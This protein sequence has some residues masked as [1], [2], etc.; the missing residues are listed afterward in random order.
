[1]EVRALALGY[2]SENETMFLSG[3]MGARAATR[4]LPPEG[5]PS[6]GVSEASGAGTEAEEPERVTAVVGMDSSEVAEMAMRLLT[7]G[8]PVGVP[9]ADAEEAE[10]DTAAV[11]QTLMRWWWVGRAKA[12]A[13]ER[14]RTASDKRTIV[15]RNGMKDWR[16]SNESG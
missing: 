5:A 7:D 14:A 8:E 3:E 11:W 9:L 15:E 10:A 12:E 13:T 16:G 1:M 2:E 6:V 4:P